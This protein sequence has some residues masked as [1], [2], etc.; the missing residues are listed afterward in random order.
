MR[1]RTEANH[2]AV[3]LVMKLRSM[4]NASERRNEF[5]E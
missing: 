1:S 5:V 2:I 3:E 4:T